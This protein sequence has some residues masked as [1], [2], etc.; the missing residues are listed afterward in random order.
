MISTFDLT[1]LGSL[2]SAGGLVFLRLGKRP[3]LGPRWLN[4]RQAD[5]GRSTPESR[6]KL[7]Q[8]AA[9]AGTRWLTV[10]TLTLF[11][12]YAH[13]AEEGYLFGPWS[14]VMFHILF[15][16]ACWGATAWRLKQAAEQPTGRTHDRSMSALSLP[17]TRSSRTG[18]W[19]KWKRAAL[20]P[21]PRAGCDP[22]EG[23]SRHRD[24]QETGPAAQGRL[25]EDGK[26]VGTEAGPQRG[27]RNRNRQHDPRQGF[28]GDQPGGEEQPTL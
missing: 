4:R 20:S 12:A 23:R 11:F 7:G 19:C 28:T 14:D 24:N 3:H 17:D 6:D 21:P 27:Q 26:R 9:I 25:V 22:I 1:L 13:G 8:W 5:H 10:G 18:N 16:S 15:V 2:V